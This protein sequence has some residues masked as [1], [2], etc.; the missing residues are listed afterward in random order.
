MTHRGEP[1][2]SPQRGRTP[3]SRF[4]EFLEEEVAALREGYGGLPSPVEARDIWGDIWH[5][6]AHNS[7]AI[8]G[9]TLILREVEILLREGKAVGEKPLKDYLEVEGY[10]RAAEWIYDQAR[11]AG[12][13]TSDRFVTLAEVRH[14]HEV[15]LTPVWDVAPHPDA[16]AQ[17]RPGN[18]RRHNIEPFPGG[19]RPPDWTDVP[20]LTHDW[21]ESIQRL[22]DALPFPENLALWHTE[23]ERIHPFIDGNGRT[24]RL[25]TNL[26]LIRRGYPPA[27]IRKNERDRYLRALRKA[28]GGDLGPLG[29][30]LA[31]AILATLH[32]FI[33]PAVAGPYRLVP[34][35]SLVDGTMSAGALRGA[36]ER[37]RLKAHQDENGRWLSSRAWVEEYKG[38]RSR[39][40]RPSVFG[41]R[42]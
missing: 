5:Q 40:G 11:D 31:R 8:E 6:E 38:N 20:M 4:Y 19:M 42:R 16:T 7:T 34:L 27:I 23:F 1:D 22:D 26:I 2:H 39:R 9:N 13:W 29:E 21:V 14:V 41:S 25:V 15:A 33:I 28:D 10:G 24:G 35:L 3:R 32:R 36:A 18:F 12:D 17:E 37:G 30:F